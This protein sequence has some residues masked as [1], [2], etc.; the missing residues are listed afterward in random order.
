M[1]SV[2]EGDF[3]KIH[4][5]GYRKDNTVFDSTTAREPLQIVVGGELLIPGL[6]RAIVGMKPGEVKR[7]TVSPEDGYGNIDPELIFTVN[8]KETFNK[9]DVKVGQI[10][11]L[12]NDEI[13]VLTLKVIEVT[14]DIVRLDGN[15]ELAGETLDFDLELLDIISQ[16]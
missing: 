16:D 4:Y 9:M 2:K 14:D 6:E 3:V 11:E 13:G 7:I 12:P 1:V 10:I 8:R 5:T 15:H